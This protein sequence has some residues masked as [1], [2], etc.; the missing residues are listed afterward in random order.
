MNDHASEV[1]SG[2]R[3]EFGK[4]WSRF[5]TVVN[6]SR[7]EHAQA[8]IQELLGDNLADGRS[9]LDA[10]CGSG[11][12]SL[13]ARRLG[14]D[15]VSF[16]YDPA[17]VECTRLVR[18]RYAPHDM[19]WKLLEGSVLDESFVKSLGM[20]DVVYS[21]GVLHHTGAMWQALDLV[22]TRVAERGLLIIAIYNDQGPMSRVWTKIKRIYNKLPAALKLP[23]AILVLV[24]RE[25]KIALVP[26]LKMKPMAYVSL[27]KDAAS[28][29]QRGMSRWHDFIDWVG[30]YPF[31]VAKPEEI[32]DFCK[33]RGFEL[34][35]LKTVAGELGCNEYVFRRNTGPE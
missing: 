4:N 12:F 23:F 17:S 29:S 25:V 35:A 18:E 11:I 10:G 6:D 8:S 27:W 9:F 1:A 2:S 32:F 15:V 33:R 7:L 34:Q 30:G 13:A 28:R 22:A 5:L 31:E 21:W 16:D 26:V 14:M 20:F 19:Q 3:F 24:P